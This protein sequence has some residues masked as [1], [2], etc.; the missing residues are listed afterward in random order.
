[1]DDAQLSEQ[2]QQM[3]RKVL[4]MRDSI[5]A[6]DRE[7]FS[8]QASNHL[9]SHLAS[10]EFKPSG[11]IGVFWP[12]RSEIDCLLPVA[13]LRAQSYQL[14]LP[15]VVSETAMEFRFWQEGDQLEPAGYGSM[16]PAQEA[17]SVT[18]DCLIMPLSLFDL[19]RQRAGYGGGFY[20]RYISASEQTGARPLLIGLAY[21][22]QE[23]DRVPVGRYDQALDWIV[24]DQGVI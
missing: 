5:P 24:T 1:M 17:M 7:A 2:K 13:S 8:H 23:V 10:I 4:S 20:D 22:M 21:A 3:R 19:S 11:T 14:A 12:I 9:L 16:G 15:V 6:E 18:P